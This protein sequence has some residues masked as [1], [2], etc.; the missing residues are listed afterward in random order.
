[1]PFERSATAASADVRNSGRFFWRWVV[2]EN[3]RCCGTVYDAAAEGGADV[4]DQ[5]LVVG[6]AR[7]LAERPGSLVSR[8]TGMF[9]ALATLSNN[10]Q[11][12]RST[13]CSER[14]EY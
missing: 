13:S 4:P 12:G 8:A 1:M 7:N 3:G 10:Y 9:H 5:D 6:E 2:A 14:A 11:M